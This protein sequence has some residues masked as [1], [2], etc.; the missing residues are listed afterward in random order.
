MGQNKSEQYVSDYT[1]DIQ[2][3]L[4][5]QSTGYAADRAA[6]DALRN[7]ILDPFRRSIQ[8]YGQDTANNYSWLRDAFMEG[9]DRNASEWGNYEGLARD[10][11][12]NV[13]KNWEQAKGVYS[14]MISDPS[15]RG[16]D[17]QT[18]RG[19][20]ARAVES[21]MAGR[22][23]MAR[24]MRKLSAS[25]GV[26]GTGAAMR[27][28]M[29][30]EEMFNSQNLAAQRDIGIAQGEAKRSDL[31]SALQGS[32]NIATLEDAARRGGLGMIG[33]AITSTQAARQAG[34]QGAGQAIEGGQAARAQ[35]LSLEG[36]AN[37]SMGNTIA[38]I[39]QSR[40]QDIA[41]AQTMLSGNSSLL[42]ASQLGRTPGFWSN[43]ASSFA[44]G[45]GA[46][47]GGGLGGSIFPKKP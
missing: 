20:M 33:S 16:Y 15:K 19:M 1:R 11:A 30:A 28:M 23:N 38:Q 7:E 27:N 37:E 34:L 39:M 10:Y 25:S 41:N 32:T 12:N 44:G 18:M 45:L 35:N 47:L 14:G 2:G 36:Q 29:N 31:H 8:N 3:A 6:L 24:N 17:D 13:G 5:G 40:N 26:G 22:A 46:G 42:N 21:G 43:L 4:Q 9:A